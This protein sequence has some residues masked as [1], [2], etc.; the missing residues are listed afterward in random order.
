MNV[1]K[2]GMHF[3]WLVYSSPGQYGF[4]YNVKL[5]LAL[6]IYRPLTLQYPST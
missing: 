3:L 6:S 4:K 5:L 2:S 1:S